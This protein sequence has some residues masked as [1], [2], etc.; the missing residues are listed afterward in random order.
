MAIDQE[1]NSVSVTDGEGTFVAFTKRPA[2]PL[3]ER[4]YNVIAELCDKAGGPVWLSRASTKRTT[5]VS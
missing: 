4:A 1:N 3:V 5:A 2:I